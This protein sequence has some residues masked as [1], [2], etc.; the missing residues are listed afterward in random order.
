M[1]CSSHSLPETPH[2]SSI[3]DYLEDLATNTSGLPEDIYANGELRKR[4]IS[5]I[6]R[7]VP[8]LETPADTSQRVLYDVFELSAARIG[9]DLNIFIILSRSDE[10]LSTLE[11]ARRTGKEPDV[12]LMTRILKYMASVGLVREVDVG[13]WTSSN[14][15]NNLVEDGYSAGVCHAND[16]G[17]PAYAALPAFLRRHAYHLLGDKTN[18]AFAMGQGAG[19]GITFYDWLQ[20]RPENADCFHTFMRT[21][22]TG[23]RTWLERS[24][25]M[26]LLA[27]VFKR[28]SKNVNGEARV[29]FVD[30]GGGIGQQCNA[31]KKRWPGLEGRII[32]EDLEEVVARAEVGEGIERVGVNFFEEQP[33]KGATAYYFRSIL[34]NWPD[35]SCRIILKNIWDAMDENSFLLIDELV[36]PDKGAHKFETQLDMTMLA[37]LNGEARSNSHWKELL[38]DSW[39]IVKDIAYYEEE[40]R[41]AVIVAKKYTQP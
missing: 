32:L 12:T 16:N 38:A 10:A 26:D 39:F 20:S 23:V 17:L 36:V 6:R 22:R 4:L 14:Y 31:L 13:M 9:M 2:L 8:E 24:D 28:E 27:E 35:T 18:T 40:A 34:R 19:L 11:L 30:V 7:L 25:I 5:A 1:E 15:G 29:V 37:M 33:V 41:E 21:H 3:V